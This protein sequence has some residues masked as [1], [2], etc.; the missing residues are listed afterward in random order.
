MGHLDV[1]LEVDVADYVG[2]NARRKLNILEATVEAEKVGI[3]CA[4]V[5]M[6][7]MERQRVVSIVPAM[8]AAEQHRQRSLGPARKPN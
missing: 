5:S 6:A 3:P 8:P 4:A 2:D 7:G 1:D